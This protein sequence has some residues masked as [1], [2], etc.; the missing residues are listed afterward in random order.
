MYECPNCGGNLK[1]DILRQQLSCDYCG[2]QADPYSFYKEKDAQEK[3]SGE[4]YEATVFTCPQCG[5]QIVSEDTTAA[6][7]C[8]FCGAS[9]ILDSRVEKQRRPQI[10]VPFTKTKEDCRAS[11]KKMLRR[12]FFAPGELKDERF[13]EKFRGI[14]MPYW[15][16]SFEKKGPVAFPGEK[17]YRRGSYL[18]TDHYRI[19]CELEEAYK[20][21]AYDASASF[22]DALSGAIAPF[23]LRKGKEFVPSFLSGFYADTSDV[24]KYVY[25]Q[26]AQ[27]FVIRDGGSILAR[28]PVC[29]KYHAGQGNGEYAFRSALRPSS[30]NVELAMVPVWFLSYR[31]G[32]RVSYAV[33][34]GQTGKAAA[35]LPVDMKRYGIGSFLLAAPLFFLLNLFLTITPGTLLFLSMVLAVLCMGISNSQMTHILEREPGEDRKDL[36][37]ERHAWG[38]GSFGKAAAM[39]GLFYMT[40]LL[41]SAFLHLRIMRGVGGA[42]REMALVFLNI[43]MFLGFSLAVTVISG[44]QGRRRGRK[45][46]GGGCWKEKWPVLKKPMAGILAAVI[47]LILDPVSDWFYYIGALVSMAMVCWSFLDIIR[48]HNLLATQRLPHLGRRGGD[49]SE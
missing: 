36:A 28:N 49:E 18:I 33:V 39:V 41:P 3:V 35:H 15:V 6:T 2:T 43:L 1:F 48:Q 27:D 34:N 31:K 29:R 4:E 13:I 38:G 14:Y 40:A 37:F 42:G 7:F 21:L 25:L 5:G 8:S 22:S 19:S 47:I 45:P 20:G 44:R 17:T 10:I 30:R 26:D 12:A 24:E 23:D 9:T 11:Y 46:F 32:D 16:Y